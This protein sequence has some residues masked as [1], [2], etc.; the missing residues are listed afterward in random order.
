MDFLKIAQTRQSCR[1]YDGSISVEKEKIDNLLKA[2]Q[3]SPSSCNSQPYH[4]TVCT[5]ESAKKVAAATSGMG[6]N[7]FTADVPIMLVISEMPYNKT[8]AVGAKIKNNDYKS[9]D[10]GIV[11]AYITSQATSDGLASCIIGWF[12]D[13][14]IRDICKLDN[15]VRLVIS[16]GYAKADDKFRTKKRKN[17]SELSKQI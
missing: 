16:I 5:G 8:A 1:N 15:P 13:K 14:A 12:D 7:K 2:A 9:I 11:A 17:L 10:I 3:L 6:I 4:I